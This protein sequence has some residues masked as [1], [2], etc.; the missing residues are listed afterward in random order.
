MADKYIL[1]FFGLFVLVPIAI[2]IARANNKFLNFIFIALVFG[3]T[4]PESL[5]GLPTDINFFSRE[6]Y[7][8]TTRGV[9]ISYLDLLAIILLFSSYSAR[10]REGV[11]FIK[12]A[13]YGYLK[14]F[15]LWSLLTVLLISDPKI[16]G[17]FE[18]TKI[19]RGILIFIAVSVFLRSPE[20]LRLFLYVL[21]VIVF[22]EISIVLSDRYLHGVHRVRGTFPHPNSLSMYLL[23]ILPFMISVLFAQD[24]SSRLKKLCVFASILIAGG[25]ILTISRTGFATMLV[26]VFLSIILNTRRRWTP[27]NISILLLVVIIAALMV[28]K[29]WDSLAS[30]F[31]NFEFENEYLSDQ[32]DRGSYFRKGLPALYENPIFGI[33]L[34]NWSYWI[35]NKYAPIAG[36]ESYTYPSTDYPPFEVNMQ[37]APAHNL[38]LITAVELG[39]VGLILLIALFLKW[40]RI[41]S[42]GMFSGDGGFSDRIRIGA[43]LSLLGILMQSV[44]EWEFR[45]TSLFFFGHISMAVAAYLYTEYK[46]GIKG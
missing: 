34:N 29:S 35:S 22:Y 19:A 40:L 6:W 10:S 9:E 16:F 5:F 45:Q 7:R 26:I 12:P 24:V 30:R 17:F 21:L 41:A 15:F 39:L 2:V 1:F 37:Q 25:I 27:K 36:Y 8:G 46:K 23:Q 38:Y 31:I 20:Q 13:S 32:G 42:I 3:T 11:K 28:A 18:I 33:G 4:Q 43:L 44:T 14:L